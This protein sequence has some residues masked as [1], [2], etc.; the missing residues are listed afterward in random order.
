MEPT[1]FVDAR[2]IEKIEI[3][4]RISKELGNSLPKADDSLKMVIII[5]AKNESKIIEESLRS[6]TNQRKSNNALFDSSSF[7]LLILCHNC[8]D[9]TYQVC[10]KFALANPQIVIHPLSWN[11]TIANT[12]GSARRI[13]MNI[14]YERIAYPNGLIIST[15]ADTIP[16]KRWL[17]NLEK[18]LEQEISLVCGFINADLKD[19]VGQ[20][21]IYLTAK[22]E[23][24]LLKSKL[25]AKILP[26]FND[27]WPRHSY[28]WGSN[29]AIKKK[30][31]KA[32]GGIRPLHYLE[33]VN[34]YTK[35]VSEGYSVRHCIKT[36]VTT[37]TRLDS[38]CDEGFGE[39]LQ[40][41]TNNE[42]VAYN[43]EGLEKLLLRFSIYR[44]IKQLYDSYCFEILSK[45]SDKAYIDLAALNNMFEQSDRYESMMIQMEKYL[46]NN[47]NWNQTFPNIGVLQACKELNTYFSD[48]EPPIN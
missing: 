27:P 41:W 29:M 15:D 8:N 20:A 2:E 13:L 4:D 39:E 17:Y 22:E 30:V 7:E 24:L 45:I 44:L 23:Y 38:R 31:Y 25:E 11:S 1:E 42:G 26:N 3:I 21:K 12:V 6:I 34:L 19:L 9:K 16:D 48:S 43:V 35:V 37:S 14:A 32:I 10:L 47:Q 46:N 40:A 18:Y 36:K 28:H 5:P 33:D